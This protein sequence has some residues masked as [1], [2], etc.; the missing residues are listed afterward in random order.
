MHWFILGKIETYYYANN[1]AR[2][3]DKMNSII[4][5]A[6]AI[7]DEARTQEEKIETLEAEIL[8]LQKT[9]TPAKKSSRSRTSKTQTQD[10]KLEA[11]SILVEEYE[12]VVNVKKGSHK[13]SPTIENR[14]LTKLM[15][16]LEEFL[17][18]P[19]IWECSQ[20]GTVYQPK[21]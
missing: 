16:D 10:S 9:T 13:P 12:L 7:E 1:T 4:K 11:L 20:R 8:N 15:N 14:N 2:R 17:G 19:A 21:D 3:T 18:N 6:Q 5:H